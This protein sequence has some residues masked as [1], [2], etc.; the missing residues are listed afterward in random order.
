[1]TDGSSNSASANYTVTS[2]AA[3][4]IVLSGSSGSL[5]SGTTRTLTATIEDAAGN[6]VTSGPDSTDS[7]TFSQTTGTG[8]VTGLASGPASA[9]VATDTVTGNL[10]GPVTLKASGTINGATTSSNT[11]TFSVTPGTATQ[12]VLSGLTTSL[13]SG[14]TRTLTATIEDAAGNTVT[15]G[16]D[17]T[18]SITFSQTTGTGSVTGLTS[19]PASAGVATDTVTG[20]LAGPVTL[21]A[22]GT[23]NGATASANTL[24]FT[25]V[26]GSASS[27]TIVSGSGQSATVGAA[28]TNPL[29]AL[30]SDAKGNP[31]SGATVTFAAPGSGASATF[32]NATPTTGA[33]G[34]ASSGTVTAG[35]TAGSYSVSASASGA[36][37]VSFG[38]TNSPGAA[39]K[40]AFTT[41]P[42][43]GTNV[44]AGAATTLAVS[45]EDANGNVETADTS[46]T[47]T[48]TIGNNPGSSALTCTNTG[49]KGPV[50]V[51]AGV[52]SFTCSLNKAGSS[53]TLSATSTPAHGTATTNSFNI[54]ASSAA[55]VAVAS[56][57]SQSA[58]VGAAFTNPL[59]ALV[60]DANGNPVSGATVTFT[61]PSS[62]ASGT[63]ANGT[64]T[65]TATTGAN[66]QATSSTFT[67]GTSAGSYSVSAAASGATSASFSLT[68]NP[69]AAAKVV[70]TTQP[71]GTGT[72]NTSFAQQPVVT[73]EDS[74]GN[75][76]TT[77]NSSQ[78]MLALNNPNNVN[79][80]ALTCTP[81][82]LTVTGGVA[83]FAGCQI[84]KAGTFSLTATDGSL[85]SATSGTIL[86]G[87]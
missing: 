57:S 26:A 56:G 36:T 9:G 70:F 4:K 5:A 32:A 13:A 79:S 86:L 77:D 52:A 1:V 64:A 51:A 20:N 34:Q 3:T 54:V 28:F 63:F 31:V 85:T 41:Q 84:T 22:S 17:S 19:G 68:N 27:V 72:K 40:L 16:P 55:A 12:I 47:V 21:K 25:V 7:I 10:A 18:D 82:P 80:V 75:R 87:N 62:G 11:L 43:S 35:T 23:I 50:T 67:A 2:G 53:Y 30:V 45:V 46:T 39:S 76:V 37:S 74:N 69:G 71:S 24:N 33:N 59:V 78:V 65:T 49:G 60:T 44:T 61:A 14:S 81:N 15:S 66:G 29:I 6:T 58:T 48:M 8:S 73:V 83:T 38:L 42:S